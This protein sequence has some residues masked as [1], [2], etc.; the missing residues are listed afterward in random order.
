MSIPWIF[1]VSIVFLIL[2]ARDPSIM[3]PRRRGRL[4]RVRG[5][6]MTSPT[7][8]SLPDTSDY[9]PRNLPDIYHASFLLRQLLLPELVPQILDEAEYWLKSTTERSGKVAVSDRS[10]RLPMLEQAG[11]HYLSSEPIGDERLRILKPIRK[12]A[13]TITSK[14]QGVSDYPSYHGTYEQSYTWFEAVTRGRDVIEATRDQSRRIITNVHAGKEYKT[15]VVTWR[16]NAENEEEREWVTTNLKKG[17]Q[18]DITVW[19]RFP[20]WTN[21]VGSARIDVFTA[22]II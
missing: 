9:Y 3:L 21:N 16:Y 18:V 4:P 1:S 15:H 11:L 7:P 20:G 17:R 10:H 2:V 14:D 13:F 6:P 22:T 8:P 19:A 5:R 12:V